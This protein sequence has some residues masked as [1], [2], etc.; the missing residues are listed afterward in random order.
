MPT[1]RHPQPRGSQPRR[2]RLSRSY[3]G[4]GWCRVH[5]ITLI[6]HMARVE[7]EASKYVSAGW[8][9]ERL[10]RVLHVR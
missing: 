9:K 4:P 7:E 2:D 3:A 6:Q 8:A 1:P 5:K 10:T